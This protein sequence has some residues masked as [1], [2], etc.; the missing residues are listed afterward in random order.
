MNRDII[1]AYV[2]WDN[3]K[4]ARKV[5]LYYSRFSLQHLPLQKSLTARQNRSDNGGPFHLI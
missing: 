4:G 3:F 5:L 1:S 2:L